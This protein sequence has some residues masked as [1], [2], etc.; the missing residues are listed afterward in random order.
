MRLE[1]KQAKLWLVYSIRFLMKGLYI[2]PVKKNRIYLSAD[3]GTAISCNPK[4][5]YRYLRNHFPG[6]Y[7]YIWEY[8]K[9]APKSGK[10]VKFVKPHTMMANF[11]MLTSK[12]I[13]SN[14]GLG[15]YI[16]KRK[17]QCFINT[18]HGGGA[19]KRVGGDTIADPNSVEA[20]INRLCGSQTDIFISSSKKFTEVMSEA[21]AVPRNRFMECGMPRNDLLINGTDKNIIEK[22][23]KY[24]NISKDKKIVLFAPTYRGVEGQADCS[25]QIDVEKCLAALKE[26][27]GGEWVFLMRKHHFVKEM[28][29]QGCLDAS[30]YPDMQELL[31]AVDVFMTDYSSTIWDYSLM[32]K[33]GFLFTPDIDEYERDRS[34]YS[35]PETWAFPLAKSNDELKNL[36]LSYDEVESREKIMKHHSLL[37]G[38]DNG[39]AAKTICGKIVGITK[40]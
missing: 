17:N 20:K 16:P 2:F 7:E 12:I 13:I 40:A 11:Y 26:R 24:F 1:M 33:P 9:K 22:V 4:F 29:N 37:A 34:F 25:V 35:D 10:D 36:I 27:F 8:D 15:S 19:Y 14:D 28:D 18:W 21:K 32:F 3:R 31:Y 23:K 30:G 38:C 39:K 5:I 6:E